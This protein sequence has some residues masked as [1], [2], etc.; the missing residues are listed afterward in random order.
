[1][2]GTYGTYQHYADSNVVNDNDPN[3]PVDEGSGKRFKLTFDSDTAKARIVGPANSFLQ[4][5]RPVDVEF[6]I[7]RDRQADAAVIEIQG[8]KIVLKA[9]QWCSAPI[10]KPPALPPGST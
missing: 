6:L 1:M 3:E 5:P 10:S 7:H 4:S 2:L 9:G 8:R